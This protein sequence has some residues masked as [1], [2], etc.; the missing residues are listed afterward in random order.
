MTGAEKRKR[1]STFND[2]AEKMWNILLLFMTKAKKR[3]NS[4]IYDNKRRKAW[5]LNHLWWRSKAFTL[6]NFDGKLKNRPTLAH[7]WWKKH[8]CSTNY[9]HISRKTSVCYDISIRPLLMKMAEIPQNSTTLDD[10]SKQT[11]KTQPK[12][13]S[14]QRQISRTQGQIYIVS[15]ETGDTT[16]TQQKFQEH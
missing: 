11:A 2:K 9:V 12:M 7:I 1:F 15:S 16:A 13:A 4:T 10:I 3:H 5:T 14:T 6:T 8:Q